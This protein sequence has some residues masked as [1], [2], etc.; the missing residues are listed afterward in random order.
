MSYG[1]IHPH[2]LYTE[3]LLL[4][5]PEMSDTQAIETLAGAYEIA[6]MTLNIPHPYPKGGA[7][8]W[9][10]QM[11]KN[12]SDTDFSFAVTLREDNTFIGMCG[13]HGH[14]RFAR[15]EIGYWMGVPYWG[16]GY[17][18]EAARRVVQ[19]GFEEMNLT[20][21]QATYLTENPASRRVMEKIGMTYEGTLRS[22]VQK[23]D[24][25]KDLGM[26]AIIR[27]EWEAQ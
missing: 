19:F 9:L 5:A 6:R 18:T 3:R 12:D 15:A 1:P 23:H 17:M 16:K 11:R 8:K 21:I 14:D 24:E 13:I 26:C 22:Y 25:D 27:S 20:R 10:T 2:V 7:V 4:R